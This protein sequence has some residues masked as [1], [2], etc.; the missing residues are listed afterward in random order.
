MPASAAPKA[1]FTERW[2]ELFEG[3]SDRQASATVRALAVTWADGVDEPGYE[4]VKAL[5][6]VSRGTWSHEDYWEWAR[7]R[8]RELTAES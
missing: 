4:D 2:P 6:D 3:L 5:T 1:S 8:A 7:Q